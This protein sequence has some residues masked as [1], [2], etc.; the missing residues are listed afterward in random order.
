MNEL[1]LYQVLKPQVQV[2]VQVLR[3]KDWT[4]LKVS[5]SGVAYTWNVN[6]LVGDQYS[7]LFQRLVVYSIMYKQNIAVNKYS[8]LK[9]KY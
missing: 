8:S 9:Y 2:Q 6:L 5:G 1:E 7:I 3:Y 4:A